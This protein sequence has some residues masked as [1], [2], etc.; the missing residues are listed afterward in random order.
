MELHITTTSPYAR[1]VQSVILEK[2]LTNRVEIVPAKTRQPDSPYYALNPSGRV[3]FL[4]RDDGVGMED[5]PLICAYLDQIDGAPSLG[6]PDG[7]SEWEFRRLEALARSMMDG[8]AVLGRELMRAE[9]HRSPIIIEHE[10]QRS[11]RMIDLWERE[12]AY[13]IMAGDLNMAQITL[14]CGLPPAMRKADF[15]WPAEHALLGAWATRI[16]AHPSIKATA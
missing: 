1:M 8:H 12:I 14:V 7:E 5:S 9:E 3:P 11:R 6:P 13:P 2:G 10:K 4:V 16:A 15:Q